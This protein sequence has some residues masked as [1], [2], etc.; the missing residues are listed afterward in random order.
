MTGVLLLPLILVRNEVATVAT[1]APVGTA[2]EVLSGVGAAS[3]RS[4]SQYS[5][6]F[7]ARKHVVSFLLASFRQLKSLSGYPP[8]AH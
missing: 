7:W 1:T 5:S 3:C 6:A 8:A 4:E 2:I